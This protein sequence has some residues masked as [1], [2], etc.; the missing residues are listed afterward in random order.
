[1]PAL[2]CD[3]RNVRILRILQ[4]RDSEIDNLLL[5]RLAFLVTRVEMVRETARL[6]RVASIKELDYRAGRVHASGG[7]DSWPKPEPEIVCCHALAV[8]ATGYVDQRAQTRINDTG[9]I[10]ESDGYD[11]AVFAR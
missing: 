6:V 8:S 4:L 1:M 10:L 3:H 5:H 2:P 9:E 11:R 7:V